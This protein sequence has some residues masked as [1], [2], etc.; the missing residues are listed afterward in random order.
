MRTLALALPMPVGLRCWSPSCCLRRRHGRHCA[1][2]E[3]QDHS[4]SR[5]GARTRSRSRWPTGLEV[6]LY[7][8]DPL[9]A[10]PIHMNFDAAG[11][12]VGRQQRGLSARQA[13]PG[14]QRQD[15][16]ARRRR[17]RR[18]GRK[19]HGLCRRPADSHR[20]RAGRR[21]RLCGQ[22]HRAAALQGHRRRRPGR[23]A[24]RH[25]LG[26]RHR[27]HASHPAH[28]PL[29]PRRNAVLQ[30]VDL[31]SQPHRNA[32][33]ACA[34]STAAASG[35][36]GPRRCS[37]KSSPAAC[38]IPGDTSSTAGANRSPPTAPAARA[39]T[40]SSPAPRCSPMPAPPRFSKGLN[41]GSPKHCGLE[42]VSGRHFPDDWQ[43]NLI[44]N[45]FRAHRVC[46]FVLTRD[47]LGLRLARTG[48]SHQDHAR[49]L[50]A[51]R[52]QDGSR[53]RAL[54]RRLVQPD[55]SA[56]RSRF[57]R[58]APRPHARPHLAR[59]GQGTA[60]GRA[61]QARRRLDRRSCSTSLARAGRLHPAAR[62]AAAQE[63]R[64]TVVVPKLDAWV[65][66]LDAAD[67]QLRASAARS[68]VDLSI[69][70][71]RR[72]A[73][74]GRAAALAR[75]ITCGPRPRACWQHGTRASRKPATLLAVQVDDEHPQVRLEAVRALAELAH[76][77][78]GRTGHAGA[79]SAGRSI[80]RSR[81]VADRP[82][83]ASRTGCRRCRPGKLDFDGNVRST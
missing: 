75:T 43:G 26:L 71:R 32:A 39:S 27:R 11:P 37:S 66:A 35:S 40:T 72:A 1:Q 77:R 18:P 48:R 76:R 4:R 49:G 21:R 13:G 73:A 58:R 9:L 28:A 59:D 2:R 57:S 14:G 15:P 17:R 60:A 34:G 38:A 52:R 10:K 64:R 68:P 46:R 29:G 55:H 19:D 63:P 74:A 69:A 47:R 33:T 7:A 53:R 65:D 22:Q 62:Q 67:P 61:A 51:D 78:S 25:A 24:P 16:G 6:N 36:S 80:S 41:P 20:R 83:S 12:A 45:D 54:H 5:S 70:R 42:V 23:H 81:L 79:R 30:P 44:T 56:R 82:R 3:L 31:H 50:S 8:A